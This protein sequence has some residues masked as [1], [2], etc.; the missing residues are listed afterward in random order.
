MVSQ[1][2]VPDCLWT[3]F[4]HAN[5]ALAS[6]G[7]MVDGVP[8]G[9]WKSYSEL[10]ELISEGARENNLPEGRWWFYDLGQVREEVQYR[11]GLKHGVQVLYL[12]GV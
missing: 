2:E 11:Q 7:C 3:K 8:V 6:E 10:G 12:D 1:A 4:E 9:V 5:G